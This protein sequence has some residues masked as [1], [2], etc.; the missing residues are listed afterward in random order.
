MGFDKDAAELYQV[1]GEGTE[2]YR[3]RIRVAQWAVKAKNAARAKEE[4]W[5]A[6]QA[7]V[8]E[9]DRNYAL[10]LLVE[11]HNI[12]STVPALIDKLA[13]QKT[14]TAEEQRVRIELLRQTGQYQKAIDL[15][16][17]SGSKSLDPELRLD[18]RRM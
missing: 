2:L 4:S 10:S 13:E 8:L 18:L 6:V 16:T 1:S 5:A 17:S 12:D 9:R 11:A 14:L 7:A 3:Q 15:F